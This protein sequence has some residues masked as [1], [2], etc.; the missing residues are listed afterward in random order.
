MTLSFT[1][2]HYKIDCTMPTADSDAG[3]AVGAMQRLKRADIV[4][5]GGGWVGLAMAKEITSRTSL[6]VV[7]LERG[8]HRKMADYVT[9]M[10]ELDYRP[11][12]PSGAEPGR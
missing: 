1:I 6:S 12:P 3:P 9:G 8:P 5:A 10:D 4:I 11:A 7:V 2:A